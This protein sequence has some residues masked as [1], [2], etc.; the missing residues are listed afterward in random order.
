MC[1]V[2]PQ[3]VRK[4]LEHSLDRRGAQG[5]EG[6]AEVPQDLSTVCASRPRFSPPLTC[7]F[8][9]QQTQMSTGLLSASKHREGSHAKKK[10][11][12][13]VNHTCVFLYLSFP[14]DVTGLGK[15]AF[16]MFPSQQILPLAFALQSVIIL[17]QTG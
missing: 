15:V 6:G 10:K 12:K 7:P 13:N 4:A 1:A 8:A 11:K 2:K 5:W 16:Q 9:P 14:R 17:S 3:A